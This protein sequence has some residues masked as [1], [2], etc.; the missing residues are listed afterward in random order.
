MRQKLRF[1]LPSI[2]LLLSLALMLAESRHRSAVTPMPAE[3]HFRVWINAPVSI[4]HSLFLS[5]WDRSVVANCSAVHADTCDS[6]T[7]FV[8]KL[9]FLGG[10]GVL[11]YLIG[12]K[13][14]RNRDSLHRGKWL[15]LIVD[16]LLIAVGFYSGLV[17]WSQWSRFH[18]YSTTDALV[19]AVP[20]AAWAAVLVVLYG[21]DLVRSV[22]NGK[23]TVSNNRGPVVAP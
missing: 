4:V 16:S 18:W 22:S 6:I 12:A 15:R 23:S 7:T 14:E 11:W 5:L 13:I 3:T 19:A 1:I 9:A 2:G 20:Y 8:S 21:H 17:S 10:V